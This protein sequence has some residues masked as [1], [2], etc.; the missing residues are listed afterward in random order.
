MFLSKSKERVSQG[1]V[2]I[3]PGFLWFLCENAVCELDLP[4]QRYFLNTTVIAPFHLDPNEVVTVT[5]NKPTA[6]VLKQ[7][8]WPPGNQPHCF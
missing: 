4:K 7:I 1:S 8:A 2:L 5:E 6:A 3:I